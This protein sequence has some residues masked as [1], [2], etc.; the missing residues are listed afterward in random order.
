MARLA[1]RQLQ[2]HITSYFPSNVVNSSNQGPITA[3]SCQSKVNPVP[4]DLP[5]KVQSS[6]LSVGMRI[7]KAVP[8][9]Y[10]LQSNK[11]VN[12]LPNVATAHDPGSPLKG[13][14]NQVGTTLQPY[15]GLLGIG[16]MS[17]HMT[18]LSIPSTT[19]DQQRITLEIWNDSNDLGQGSR[20]RRLE[21]DEN[22]SSEPAS[23]I[24]LGMESPKRERP[25]DLSV[26]RS[27]ARPKRR[28]PLTSISNVNCTKVGPPELDMDDFEEAPFLEPME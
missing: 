28:M 16:G 9:G 23:H 6:L 27:F 13:S 15:C 22:D 1:K 8:E 4:S 17:P 12:F 2:D 3:S 5:P 11:D 19:V 20:K 10:K 26:Q 14:D 21:D 18:R 25:F 7:R 24:G